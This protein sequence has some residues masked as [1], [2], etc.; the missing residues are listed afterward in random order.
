MQIIV[1]G[2]HR[3]GTSLVTRIIN[4][5]GAYFASEQSS[6]GFNDENPKGF[7]ERKD[8]IACND[9]ILAGWECSWSSLAQLPEQPEATAE[10]QHTIRNIILEMDA[11]RPWVMKDPRL[12]VTLPVWRPYLEIPLCVMV[13]RDP[14]E[15]AKSLQIRNGF[16]LQHGLAL[17]EA[18][19]LSALNAA[20]GLPTLFMHHADMLADPVA[21]TRSLY[22]GLQSYKLQGLRLPSD[23]EILAFVEPKFYR[24]KVKNT[25]YAQFLNQQQQELFA[26]TKGEVS[27]LPP[28]I[29]AG[30]KEAMR[31]GE[32][33]ERHIQGLKENLM[34][35]TRLNKLM[36]QQSEQLAQLQSRIDQLASAESAWLQEKATLLQERE[37]ASLLQLKNAQLEALATECISL[38]RSHRWR[39]GNNV[40]KM[41]NA[42]RLRSDSPDIFNELA[43]R[44][45]TIRKG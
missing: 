18:Y 7:W 35:S 31:Y 33:A 44:L 23:E 40:V 1:L 39:I 41:L 34:E 26:Y 11:H 30:A 3:S 4:M 29:S 15:I 22:D 16:S 32:D 19:T 37:T 43:A 14:L 12:C 9:S 27:V 2:A 45:D 38:Q 17:W 25:D 6:I 21:A 24:S 5:M 8:V 20:S 36:F 13:Y 28:A 10:Q 42:L